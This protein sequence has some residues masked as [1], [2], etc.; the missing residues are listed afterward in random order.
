MAGGATANHLE[1][2]FKDELLAH[3]SHVNRLMSTTTPASI[4][5]T[6]TIALRHFTSILP[7]LNKVFS[8]DELVQITTTFANAVVAAK[9]QMVIWK[10]IMYLQ[11]VKGFLFDIPQARSLLVEAV[12][13]WIKPHFGR[14]DEYL[15][16]QPGDSD[17]AKDAARIAWLESVR[18][19][20]TVVAVMLDKLQ[21]SLVNPTILA[22]RNLLRQEHYNVEYLL[23]LFPR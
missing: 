11:V 12:V 7:E 1:T 23:S 9:G 15:W 14:F 17:S 5:G 22:D 20:V 6:Q 19:S 8:V 10:L 4:I 3:L 13:I 21:Q 18:L 16:T 2:K